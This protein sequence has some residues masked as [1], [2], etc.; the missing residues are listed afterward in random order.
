MSQD[1]Q[2]LVYEEGSP[3]R[4]EA[5][6]GVTTTSDTLEQLIEEVAA[7]Y[8]EEPALTT[9]ISE[10]DGKIISIGSMGILTF[11]G[12]WPAGETDDWDD[13]APLFD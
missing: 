1:E 2:M 6:T 8:E 7:K 10:S 13:D 5:R 3:S 4:L 9:D 12:N 11:V